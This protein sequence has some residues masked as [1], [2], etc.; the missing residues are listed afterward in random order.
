MIVHDHHWGS[1]AHV[2]AFGLEKLAVPLESTGSCSFLE[3]LSDFFGT[4]F[5]AIRSAADEHQP[6]VKLHVFVVDF[7]WLDRL[8]HIAEIDCMINPLIY[9][10]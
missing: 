2:H 4:G 3:L 1:L 6:S 5:F 8:H 9:A 7:C 10:P